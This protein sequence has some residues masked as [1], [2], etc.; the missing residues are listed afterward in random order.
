MHVE[1]YGQSAFALRGDA[2]TVAIDPFGDMAPLLQGRGLQ[3]EYPAI[4]G[5]AADLLLI[6]H[7]HRDHNVVEAV[8]GD[9]QIL[10]STA[11][12]LPSPLGEV[13][14]V[15][16][17][18]DEAAG[19]LRGPNTIFA[20]TLDGVRVAH[21]GD[22]GQTALRDEQAAALGA[23][24]L[25]FI[26]VGGGPTIG[27]AQAEEIAGR[28][29]ARWIVPMHYRTARIGFLEPA[30]DFLGRFDHVARLHA[31]RFDTAE[32]PDKRPLVI[33]PAAP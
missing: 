29:G 26:P 1:W 27:A 11:G 32:L 8:G 18:H 3:W 4:E 15:A 31:P 12:K 19:T 22:F 6:T 16:S 33:V 9:P 13:L 2:A 21:F 25:L 14:A 23:V 20:F 28:L 7:E 17:E 30:D 24:D 10:R 5:L